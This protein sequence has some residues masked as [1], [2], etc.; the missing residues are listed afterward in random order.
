MRLNKP[1]RAHE[2]PIN[3]HSFTISPVRL[4]GISQEVSTG[5][6]HLDHYRFSYSTC[7]TEADS[8]WHFTTPAG[9]ALRQSDVA[10]MAALT[11]RANQPF[12]G[13]FTKLCVG[14]GGRFSVDSVVFAE[15]GQ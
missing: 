13:N 4:L 10:T 1:L 2:I 12:F 11:V 15:A 7:G 14:H 6:L 8:V 9:S 3:P 5:N